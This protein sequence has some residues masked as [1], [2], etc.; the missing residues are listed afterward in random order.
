MEKATPTQKTLS[1][2]LGFSDSVDQSSAL[3]AAVSVF[4]VLL[5]FA[6]HEGERGTVN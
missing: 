4:L 3:P 1:N 5:I 2:V 6:L